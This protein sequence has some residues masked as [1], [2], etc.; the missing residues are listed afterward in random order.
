MVH[1]LRERRSHLE[2]LGWASR[3]ECGQRGGGLNVGRK[4]EERVGHLFFRAGAICTS[5]HKRLD[6]AVR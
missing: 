3:L 5:V 1:V 4:R 6:A 2:S